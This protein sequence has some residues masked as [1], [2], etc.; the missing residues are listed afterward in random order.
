MTTTISPTTN[1]NGDI[2]YIN[3]KNAS[4]TLDKANMGFV[5]TYSIC[6]YIY[7]YI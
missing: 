3:Q 7:I 1:N 2:L 4:V 6:I 5:S